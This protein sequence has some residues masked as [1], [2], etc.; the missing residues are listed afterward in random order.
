MLPTIIGSLFFASQT[1]HWWLAVSSVI[2]FVIFLGVALFRRGFRQEA[3]LNY[4]SG[5]YYWGRKRLSRAAMFWPTQIKVKAEELLAF[6]EQAPQ[7][8]QQ[9]KLLEARNYQLA[10][11]NLGFL[12][13]HGVRAVGLELATGFPHLLI[14][15][16]T[17]AGKSVLLGRWLGSLLS[18][19][20]DAQFFLVDFKA[21]ETFARFANLAGV[22]ALATDQS[23]DGLQTLL[24]TLEELLASRE[25][26]VGY[27]HRLCYVII[28][29]FPYLLAKVPSALPII[30]NLVARGRSL[31]FRVVISSQ[32]LSAIPR[33][34]L[35][36]FR[37]RIAVGNFETIELISLG[38][39]RRTVAGANSRLERPVL[40]TGW[41]SAAL[42]SLG[43]RTEFFD[44]PLPVVKTL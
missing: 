29:E 42:I 38:A 22:R 23:L 35:N 44:F 10:E 2:S 33:N 4:R 3:E 16:A 43:E 14:C 15:G 12:G 5:R 24:Q 8:A 17:G 25:A 34:L 41:C 19:Q 26:E 21:G 7:R 18:Q 37:R 30:E 31:G 13:F 20:T 40:A 39:D 11:P 36:Q 9:L 28:D 32:T 1:G 6:A 27:R